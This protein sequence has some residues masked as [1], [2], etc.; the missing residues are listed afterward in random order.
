MPT[1]T[2]SPPDL[3]KL[4]QDAHARI[5]DCE[6]EEQRL[7]LDALSDPTL[8]EELQGVQRKRADAEGQARQA[9]MAR[10]EIGRREARAIEAAEQARR[11]EA[12]ADARVLEDERR[13]AAKAVDEAG[14]AYVKA[15]DAWADVRVRQEAALGRAHQRALKPTGDAVERALLR[16][17]LDV[18]LPRG[19]LT[20]EGINT[21]PAP[22][23]ETDPG[24]PVGDESV[25]ADG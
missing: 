16:N 25:G 21:R 6:Q 19:L 4:E 14:A 2:Q 12:L 18:G 9:Q 23:A 3:D 10:D 22:L 8:A 17:M 5:A 11:D 20:I 7:A 13:A 1:A 24:Q 15:I